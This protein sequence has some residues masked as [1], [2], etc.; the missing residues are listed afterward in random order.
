M[1]KLIHL[2]I[3]QKNFNPGIPVSDVLVGGEF[4][5]ADH[6]QLPG[7]TERYATCSLDRSQMLHHYL[8]LL[9][10]LDLESK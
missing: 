9:F 2:K 5:R 10:H 7:A 6:F 3:I 8:Q 4:F 1:K